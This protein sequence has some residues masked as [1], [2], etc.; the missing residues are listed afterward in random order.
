M[1]DIS[2]YQPKN[3]LVIQQRQ[4]GDVVVTT[5]VFVHIKKK[6]PQT[7]VTIFN[8]KKVCSFSTI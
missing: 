5:P 8:R 6:F 3:I 1:K 4:L 7:K 2:K